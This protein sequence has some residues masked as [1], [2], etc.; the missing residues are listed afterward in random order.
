[1]CYSYIDE[2]YMSKRYS[3]I[4]F[5]KTFGSIPK[6]VVEQLQEKEAIQ[7]QH[8]FVRLCEGLQEG[9]CYLCG[10][11][12]EHI[13]EKSPCMHW[14]LAS[15]IKK[16]TLMRY[17]SRPLSFFRVQTYLRWVANSDK[18]FININDVGADVL[19]N[20]LHESTIRYK[21][22]EWS[23]S[24]GNTDFEGH[25]GSKVGN[26][27]H[28]HI[29]IVRDGYT[30]VKFNDTHIAFEPIDFLY[31]EMIRQDAVEV[32]PSYGAGLES[33]NSPTIQEAI[34][35][36]ISVVNDVTKAQFWTRTLI[37]PSTIPENFVDEIRELK[38]IHRDMP[39]FKLIEVLNELKGYKVQYAV[40][41]VPANSPDKIHRK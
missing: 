7:N 34:M 5:K 32:D 12:I 22:L 30:V 11:K 4:D 37:D 41:N 29:Q 3:D 39:M 40:V 24:L 16:K 26:C 18:P 9:V 19:D 20:K 14:F 15:S 27:P 25:Y 35:D 1:M 23:F 17:L 28:Y 6:D 13:D 10:E 21:N 36:N 2:E 8:D 31:M 38:E 33:L